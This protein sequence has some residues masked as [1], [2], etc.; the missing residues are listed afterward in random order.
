[1]YDAIVLAGGA[2]RRLG[3]ADKPGL[4]IAGT[5]LL[6]H[7]LAAVPDAGCVVVV[8]PPRPV[9]LPV[10]LPVTWC[11]EQPPGA[12][13]L[14]AL[15]AGL[16]HIRA[17]TVLVLAADLPSIGPA[18]PRLLA[19]LAGDGD[20]AVLSDSNG[21]ANYLAAAWRAAA[22]R[23]AMATVGDPVGAPVRRLFD[24]AAMIRVPDPQGW[25]RD[26]DTWEELAVAR[27]EAEAAAR[28]EA[29]LAAARRQTDRSST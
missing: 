13:P 24:S 19:A 5:T 26:C 6:D 2:A 20:V 11:R 18:V 7:V 12:G 29:E 17:G 16:V 4:E 3:G 22:L 27:R 8:G 14:A 23:D 15:A 10:T 1:M 28:R 25:G 9:T 21:R